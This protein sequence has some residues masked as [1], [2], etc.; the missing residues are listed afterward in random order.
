MRSP[1]GL[2]TTLICAVCACA[3]PDGGAASDSG[4]DD[5]V[6]EGGASS[7]S[8]S[9]TSAEE[10]P[11][12]EAME[13]FTVAYCRPACRRARETMGCDYVTDQCSEPGTQA[14]AVGGG[15]VLG[16]Y[17]A[18]LAACSDSGFDLAYCIILC[19]GG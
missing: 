5:D 1:A 14:V 6:D 8:S 2:V 13:A 17:P 3:P 19:K 15:Y 4:G 7:S 10:E 16:C 12:D 18:R 9:S 11:V